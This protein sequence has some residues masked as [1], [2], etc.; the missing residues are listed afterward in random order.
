VE[1]ARPT[2]QR[3]PDF[4]ADIGTGRGAYAGDDAAET[5]I[6]GRLAGDRRFGRLRGHKRRAFDAGIGKLQ[7]GK[8]TAARGRRGRGAWRGLSRLGGRDRRARTDCRQNGDRECLLHVA[9][10]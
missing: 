5:A 8:I 3:Q 2:L 9:L 7:A 10:L 6:A 4:N 1:H